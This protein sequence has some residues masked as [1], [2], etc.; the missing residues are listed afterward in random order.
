MSSVLPQSRHNS[1]VK[2][3]QSYDHVDVKAVII[4][5]KTKD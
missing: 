5:L 3:I 2:I 1:S 4:K